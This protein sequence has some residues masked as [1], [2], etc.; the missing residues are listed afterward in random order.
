MKFKV[1]W[2]KVLPVGLTILSAG[3]MI[4][5]TVLA[6]KATPKVLDDIQELKAEK[7]GISE[8]YMDNELHCYMYYEQPSKKELLYIYAKRYWPALMAGVATVTCMASATI[9]SQKSQASIAGAYA[10]VSNSFKKYRKSAKNVFGEDADEKILDDVE[11][12]MTECERKYI[13]APRFMGNTSLNESNDE[14]ERL[15]LDVYSNRYFYST[16]SRVI[17]AE[18]HTNRNLILGAEVSLNDFYDFLG[19][20]KISGGDLLWSICDEYFWIDFDNQLETLEDGREVYKIYFLF[21][22][23]PKEY[24]ELYN[25]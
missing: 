4:L 11:A 17:E 12:H 25:G 21:E 23:E 16:L 2:K 22:P 9:L 10:L 18:Y 19:I 14:E 5:T 13:S 15:F 3:G 24:W 1:N 6:V 20:D 8:V 7:K